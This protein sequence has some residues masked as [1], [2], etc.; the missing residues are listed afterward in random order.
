MKKSI[1]RANSCLSFQ[2]KKF[3]MMVSFFFLLGILFF[4][5]G[6]YG[7]WDDGDCD[8]K[9]CGSCNGEKSGECYISGDDCEG[10]CSDVCVEWN[11]D[12]YCTDSDPDTCVGYTEGTCSYGSCDSGQDCCEDNC[13]GTWGGHCVEWL[14]G[15]CIDWSEDGCDTGG[16]GDD[17]C[18]TDHCASGCP[19]STACGE[20]GN[21]PC[22]IN[23]NSDSQCPGKICCSGSCVIPNCTA[24][25]FDRKDYYCSPFNTYN[26]TKIMFD[27]YF[28]NCSYPGTC[29]AS[30]SEQSYK[31]FSSTSEICNLGCCVADQTNPL[32][33]SC[34]DNLFTQNEDCEP[35][36]FVEKWLYSC[37]GPAYSVNL[38]TP[39]FFTGSCLREASCIDDFNLLGV[40]EDCKNGYCADND[41][42]YEK[43]GCNHQYCIDVD[44][45]GYAGNG[46]ESEC[47]ED[48]YLN[49]YY[50]GR[51]RTD[52]RYEFFDDQ[53]TWNEANESC[54][55]KGGSLVQITDGE[56]F[57]ILKD[58]FPDT[59]YWV[60][61]NDKNVEGDFRWINGN[62]LNPY[63]S[64]SLGEEYFWYGGQPDNWLNEDCAEVWE[65]E[66]LNDNSC[67]GGLLGTVK[68]NYVCQFPY[69]FDCDDSSSSTNPGLSEICGN[70]VDDNCDGYVDED[71]TDL[72][73]ASW[74]NLK[75][76]QPLSVAQIE[77]SVLMNANGNGLEFLDT[78][79]YTIMTQNCWFNCNR[80]FPNKRFFLPYI[81]GEGFAGSYKFKVVIPSIGE[82]LSDALEVQNTQSN[83]VPFGNII[84]PADSISI[85]G[86]DVVQLEAIV[87]D[88]DDFL[89]VKWYFGDGNVTSFDNYAQ[90]I[91]GS[92]ALSINHSF[93]NCGLTTV[94]LVAEE[95]ER[96]QIVE[97]KLNILVYCEGVSVFPIISSPKENVDYSNLVSF[98]ASGSFVTNC[99]RGP[100]ANINFTTG[101]GESKL[102]CTYL[103]KPNYN[104]LNPLLSNPNLTIKWEL[105]D[106]REIVSGIWNSRDLT[107]DPVQNFYRYYEKPGR[108]RAVLTL[109]YTA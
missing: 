1:G 51:I 96:G 70:Q 69:V 104:E 13:G 71:C 46:S 23:C 48:L 32:G 61:L 6:V 75:D 12:G 93:S 30:L 100:M 49:A 108:H 84:Q 106:R 101:Q 107:L 28:F 57:T 91:N 68:N 79:N 55:E 63:L 34:S 16:G 76:K 14:A 9:S 86:E 64:V 19:D 24:D 31:K 81:F 47:I 53:K 21:S 15:T 88:E 58:L 60:G 44:G 80:E 17:P 40:V 27:S 66:L 109:N 72:G 39:T 25:V 42:E 35:T 37:S 82:N 41:G 10:S 5:G 2:S 87:H 20:C 98:D 56:I 8:E 90:A 85:Y 73:G 59:S 77:D 3:F 33:F 26:D 99:T 94:Y 105:A 92:S 78:I 74:S 50:P 22:P 67:N 36:S 65:S 54:I 62:I 52:Y 45:D 89:N 29:S 102:N 103:H 4:S 95:K 83:S 38:N 18:D 11:S 97:D 7:C 43:S